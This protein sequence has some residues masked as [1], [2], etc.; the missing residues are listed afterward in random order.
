MVHFLLL[1]YS[2]ATQGNSLALPDKLRSQRDCGL[3]PPQSDGFQT[4]EDTEFL[5]PS[6]GVP[7][8]E[9]PMSIREDTE[10]LDLGSNKSGPKHSGTAGLE[11]WEDTCFLNMPRG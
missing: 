10:L 6:I 4:H 7:R 9:E 3:I 5:G 8:N 11:I 1:P 2:D